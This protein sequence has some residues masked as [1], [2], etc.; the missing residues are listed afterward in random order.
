MADVLIKADG[1]R[2]EYDEVVALNEI[3][4]AITK[5]VGVC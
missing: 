4:D 2:K 3:S 5:N 1:L